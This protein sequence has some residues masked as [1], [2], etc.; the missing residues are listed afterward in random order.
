MR[1]YGNKIED[2]L[3]VE[4]ILRSLTPKFNF[5]ACSIEEA[6]DVDLIEDEQ[7]VEIKIEESET[8]MI[9]GTNNEIIIKRVNLKEE[10]EDVETTTQQ[11]IDQ[12][13]Q[14]DLNKQSGYQSNFAEKEEE[15]S[16]LTKFDVVRENDISD[17]K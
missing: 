9:V 7:E 2:V 5:V 16:L 13:C 17:K 8:I 4:K 1:I 15:L 6:N 3:I 12:K 14:T 10:V 11:P